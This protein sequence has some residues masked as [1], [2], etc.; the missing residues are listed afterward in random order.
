MTFKKY[1]LRKFILT[2]GEFYMNCFEICI[3]PN[4]ISRILSTLKK[5][6]NNVL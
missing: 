2:I 6:N 1:V 3:S 4:I 5:I